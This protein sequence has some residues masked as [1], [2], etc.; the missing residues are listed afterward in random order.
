MMNVS[1]AVDIVVTGHLCLDILPDMSAVSRSAMATPGLLSETGPIVIA[2][3]GAV[4]NTGIA[5]HILGVNVGLMATVGGDLLGNLIV[6]SVRKHDPSL[7]RYFVRV[8]EQAASYTIALTPHNEDRTFLHCPSTNDT[9]TSANVDFDLVAQAKIFHLG[10]P[11]LMRALYLNDGAETTKI[12]QQAKATGVVTSLDSARPD[13]ASLSGQANWRLILE[14]TLPYVDIFVPS[15][16][17]ILYMLRRHDYDA[18]GL[19]VL[20]YVTQSYLDELA[21]ELLAMGAIVTGFKLGEMGMVLRTADSATLRER[22]SR[23]PLDFEA[24]GGALVYQPAFETRV[25]GTTGAGDTA[26]AALLTAMLHGMNP[27]EA[28][29]MAC[30]VAGCCVEA[31]DSLGGLRSWEATKARIAAGWQPCA[32]RLPMR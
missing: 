28:L 20:D 21:D 29:Q 23:L 24:W 15:I 4:S 19:A 30:G 18:W 26:Y 17:E 12:F 25:I 22:L 6:E 13:P 31:A 11:P 5:L 16:E 32:R 2:T 3:G 9:F 10:Y 8:P 7:T 14:R 1:N 27:T